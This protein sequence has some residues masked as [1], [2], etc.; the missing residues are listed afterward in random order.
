MRK[1]VTFAN[2]IA[3][4]ALF[5]ALGGTSYAV[6]KLNGK[7]LVDGSVTGSKLAKDTL[8]GKQIKEKKLGTVP[9][10]ADTEKL[11]VSS[12]G[13]KGKVKL[14][15]DGSNASGDVLVR[16]SAGDS[17]PLL[18]NG[19]F[20][21]RAVCDQGPNGFLPRV[22][23]DTTAAGTVTDMGQVNPGEPL[24]VNNL[25]N[26]YTQGFMTKQQFGLFAAAPSGDSI[27]VGSI[28]Y[29]ANVVG[30]DCVYAAFGVG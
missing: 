28:Y 7:D 29:G 2:V 19:P 6:S 26:S 3:L 15:S 21:Y 27:S 22:F 20:T 16:L 10:S 30:S 1:H 13:K 23:L 8:T 18:T 12:Q 11:L 24:N 9:V 4:I 5:V 14:S 17:A 25:D